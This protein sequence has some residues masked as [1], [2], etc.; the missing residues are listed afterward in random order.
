MARRHRR[1]TP[2]GAL[3]L[4]SAGLLLAGGMLLDYP[5]LVSLAV[6]GA[7]AALFGVMWTSMRPKV[8]G[9]RQVVPDRVCEG[10]SAWATLS[11]TNRGRWPIW[12][13]EL[14]DGNGERV[15]LPRIAPGRTITVGSYPIRFPRRG[16]HKIPPASVGRPDP[17]RLAQS[18]YRCGEPATIVVHPRTHPVA[19]VGIERSD[20]QDGTSMRGA[21]DSVASFHSL[22]E[23]VLGD[24]YRLIHW[25][26]TARYGTPVVRHSVVPDQPAHV[27]VLDA[28]ELGYRYSARTFDEAVRAAASTCVAALGGGGR[29]ELRTTAGDV[30][31]SGQL[32]RSE[33]RD[34]M[35]DFLADVRVARGEGSPDLESWLA[36]NLSPSPSAVLTVMTGYLPASG[37][38]QLTRLATLAERWAAM[39]VV[40]FD[41]LAAGS[42]AEHA[43]LRVIEVATC[44]EYAARAA[45]T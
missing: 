44:A 13:L 39:T 15:R 37:G 2:A 10:E 1:V 29:V 23:Y 12:S 40:A 7:A 17:F 11:V 35:L 36:A 45:G 28:G 26:S 33:T 27:V 42:A 31:T 5:E 18:N 25:M 8:V 41:Q 4:L 9:S 16:K 34:A 19:V 32:P 22:R 43:R 6:S 21:M 3:V 14:L 38:G 30:V 24:D 20:L